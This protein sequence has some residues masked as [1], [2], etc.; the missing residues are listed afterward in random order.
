MSLQVDQRDR[1]LAAK[2]FE[3]MPKWIAEGKFK[4]NDMW[5][6]NRFQA[7]LE[8]FQFHR[9]GFP[10]RRLSTKC[11]QHKIGHCNATPDIPSRIAFR[12]IATNVKLIEERD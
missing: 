5:E 6:L 7:T 1:D 2:L 12:K 3:N 11:R 10:P 8:G 9:D 4:P